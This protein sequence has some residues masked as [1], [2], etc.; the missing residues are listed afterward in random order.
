VSLALEAQKELATKGYGARVVS[1]PCRELFETQDSDFQKDVLGTA[2]RFVIEAGVG[3][4]WLSYVTS[5]RY[6]ITL[7]RFGA[8]APGDVVAKNLGL[9][10][11][12]ISARV[13]ELCPQASR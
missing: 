7:E 8:S 6:L 9:S 13:H 2:P 12:N 11:E 10:V 1:I 4:G 5:A 3:R